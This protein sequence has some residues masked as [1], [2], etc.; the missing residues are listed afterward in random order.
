[1]PLRGPIFLGG[2]AES[3]KVAM[4]MIQAGFDSTDAHLENKSAKSHNDLD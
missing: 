1:M 3:D 4:V 2:L